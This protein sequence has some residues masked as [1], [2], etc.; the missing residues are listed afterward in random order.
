MLEISTSVI[1]GIMFVKLEGELNEKNFHLL[2][3]N[4]NYLLYKQRMHY[5]LIDFNQVYKVDYNIFSLLQNKMVEIFLSCGKVVL[6]GINDFIFNSNMYR[7]NVIYSDSID[8]LSVCRFFPN[9]G[10]R[11]CILP[12]ALHM[13]CHFMPQTGDNPF[14]ET[15]DIG[16][17]N[18]HVIGHLFLGIF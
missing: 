1:K 7:D 13:P 9:N 18:A 6:C 17:G 15:A 10:Q 4:I 16:L 14:F 12:K 3:D 5:F 2:E 11:E 8:A